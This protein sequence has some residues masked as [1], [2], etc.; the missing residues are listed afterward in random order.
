MIKSAIDKDRQEI[1]QIFD[2]ITQNEFEKKDKKPEK[3][4]DNGMEE[5]ETPKEEPENQK[6]EEKFEK[7]E[8]NVVFL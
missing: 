7:F 3:T 8:M 6:S 5:E 4:S 2:F 1:F